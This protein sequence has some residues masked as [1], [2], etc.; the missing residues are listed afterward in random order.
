MDICSNHL[1]VELSRTECSGSIEIRSK[2]LFCKKIR[3]E[4][5]MLISENENFANEERGDTDVE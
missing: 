1:W 4:R 2:C 5:Y 3:E